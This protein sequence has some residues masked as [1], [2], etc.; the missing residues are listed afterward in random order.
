MRLSLSRFRR[1]L[2]G[3]SDVGKLTAEQQAKLDELTALAA[4]DDDD[5]FEIEIFEGDRG[6]RLPYRKGK[7]FLAKLG[8]DVGDPP[9]AAADPA[10]ADDPPADQGGARHFGRRMA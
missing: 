2:P 1:N 5:D 10:G 3:A 9:A 7:S 8:I 6:A 4:A